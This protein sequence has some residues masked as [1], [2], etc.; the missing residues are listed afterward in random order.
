VRTAAVEG[1][2]N[3]SQVYSQK[4]IC[5]APALGSSA[6]APV[7]KKGQGV[8]PAGACGLII[9]GFWAARR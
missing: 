4:L 3:L 7:Y 9:L 1:R 5:Q 6:Q 8:I 2:A